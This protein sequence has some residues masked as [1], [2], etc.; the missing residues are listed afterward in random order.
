MDT[1]EEVNNTYFYRGHA[2]VKADE[3]FWM[4]FLERFSYYSGWEIETA[5][6]ILSGQPVLPE[7]K[8]LG[9]STRKTSVASRVSRYIFRDLRFPDNRRVAPT[10][11]YG[12]KRYT[13]RVGAAVGRL[14]PY[15]GYTQAI[16]IATLVAR[17]V[18]TTYNLIVRPSDR[19]AWVAF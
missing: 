12:T 11:G 14:I 13:T 10:V 1:F 7:P 2:G 5:A 19:I 8:G 16:L 6:M 15:L 4:I 18:R 17:E 3:L 9:K